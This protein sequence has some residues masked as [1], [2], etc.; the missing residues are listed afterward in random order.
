M[1]MWSRL[2]T[3]GGTG[4]NQELILPWGVYCGQEQRRTTTTDG[5]AGSF[6]IAGLALYGDAALL[7]CGAMM[8]MV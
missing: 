8:M 7:E 6:S 5:E 2:G 4:T 3:G 1:S